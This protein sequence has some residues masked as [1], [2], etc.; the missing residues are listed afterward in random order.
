MSND[1]GNKF[2]CYVI[3]PAALFCCGMEVATKQLSYFFLVALTHNLP[4]QYCLLFLEVLTYELKFNSNSSRH[5]EEDWICQAFN[6]DNLFSLPSIQPQQSLFIS[7]TGQSNWIPPRWII[8]I[9][10]FMQAWLDCCCS[11]QCN[12]ICLLNGSIVLG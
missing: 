2:R 12:L 1:R 11:S 6:P 10:C 3:H 4:I 9:W 8:L 5:K 7:F